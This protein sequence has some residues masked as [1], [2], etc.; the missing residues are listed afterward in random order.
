MPVSDLKDHFDVVVE[1]W[2]EGVRKP[3]PEILSRTLERLGVEAGEALMIDDLGPNLKAARA[4]GM[5]TFKASDE[6][7][8]LDYL[9][10]I[11]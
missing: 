11:A 2:R 7:S 6:K 5:D 4:L 3:D 1:S 10:T 9:Q 8:L